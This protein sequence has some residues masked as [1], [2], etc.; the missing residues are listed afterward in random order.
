MLPVTT[1]ALWEGEYKG[2]EE[3]E[4]LAW[5][6]MWFLIQVNPGYQMMDFFAK[7]EDS[8]LE[9]PYFGTYMLG[10]RFKQIEEHLKLRKA[11]ESPAYQD[12]FFWV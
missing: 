5:L 6:G 7:R 8:F 9:P 4:F 11:E 10:K 1:K 12:K 2:L 3:G